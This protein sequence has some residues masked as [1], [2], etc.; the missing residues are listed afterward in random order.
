MA[1]VLGRFHSAGDDCGIVIL[2]KLF[3]AAIQD[4]FIFGI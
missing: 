2:G 1:L 4:C 3:V